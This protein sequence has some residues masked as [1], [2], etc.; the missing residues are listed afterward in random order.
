MIRLLGGVTAFGPDGEIE[1]G[2]PK[3]RAVLALLANQP[4]AVVSVDR[5]AEELWG[6]SPPARS[7]AS[8]RGYVSNLRK[9]LAAIGA[10]PTT[11]IQFRQQGYVLDVAHDDVDLHRFEAAVGHGSA[12]LR[13]GDVAG[14]RRTLHDA[15][16]LWKGP[17]FGIGGETP[18]LS[19][20]VVRLNQRRA[21][22]VEAFTESRLALGEHAEVAADLLAEIGRE[23]YRERMRTQLATALYRSGHQVEALRGL[24]EA[25]R[26]LAEDI[27]IDAGSEIQALE[28]AILRH[29]PELDLRSTSSP[30]PS[31]PARRGKP[32]RTG[33][34][35]FGR[36]AEIEALDVALQGIR[37]GGRCVIV[38]GE[39]GIGKTAL[40]RSLQSAAERL[41]IPVGW[42]RC[43]ES[44]IASPYRSWSTAIR[45]II[46]VDKSPLLASAVAG[47]AER[48]VQGETT[49]NR[50]ATHLAVVRALRSLTTPVVIVID[51]LQW[52]DSATLA[53]LE[54]VAGEIDDLQVLLAVTVRRRAA[55]DLPAVVRDC[56]SELA[57][58]PHTVQLRLVG[59]PDSSVADW[60]RSR[61]GDR[62][63]GE[64][65][66]VLTETTDGNPFYLGEFITLLQ[67]ESGSAPGEPLRLP[68]SLPVA[69]QD[70]IRRRTSRLP[71]ATQAL[72]AIAA[73]IGRRFDL[74]ILATVSDL[75][76]PSTSDALAAAIDAALLESDRTIPGRFAFVHALVSDTL[77]AEHN[78]FDLA[79]LHARVTSAIEQHRAGQ[80]DRW[81]DELAYHAYAGASAGTS[82][83]AIAYAVS[84]ANAS[85]AAQASADEA[86]HLLRAL[87][88]M[89]ISGEHSAPE[90]IGLLTRLGIALRESG[91]LVAGRAALV[92]ACS[93]AES[94]GDDDAIAGALGALNSDDLWAGLDWS[95]FD[96]QVVAMIERALS[97]SDGGPKHVTAL[98]AAALAAELVYLDPKRSE[99]VSAKAVAAAEM[100]GDP[101][102]LARGFLQ[103]YW[104][105]SGS[106][107][108]AERARI[109]DRLIQLANSERLPPHFVP[110]AHLSRVAAAY[111]LGDLGLV[112]TCRASAAASAHPVRTPTAWAHLLYLDASLAL[113]A[114]DLDRAAGGADAVGEALWRVRRF[115][116]SSTRAGLLA[117]IRS[118]QGRVEEALSAISIVESTPYGASICWLKAWIL[119]EA[120]QEKDSA[121]ALAAFD[122]QLADD[123]YRVPLTVAGTLAAARIGDTVFLRRHLA[124]LLPIADRFACVGNGGIV[125]GPVAYAIASAQHAL[126]DKASARA[127]CRA[128]LDMS[129]SLGAPLWIQRADDL[130]TRIG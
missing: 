46:E 52:S 119:A 107:G 93:L 111:E 66:A 30:T 68:A 77:M 82:Q 122:G 17:A 13:L 57:R 108:N 101:L 47:D 72:L 96:Q 56:L 33:P 25:R 130:S 64:V 114:G 36:R 99:L 23:P 35:L 73:V 59:L 38:S 60:L 28:A 65:S 100:A 94:I 50:L 27:G 19:G 86:G 88:V 105:L 123:W 41:E 10:H 18:G 120:N 76:V 51:D 11:V 126:G 104:G 45:R 106:D 112:L 71:P 61:L 20:V 49:A 128:A 115:A 97:R 26:V 69:V 31:T 22:A 53:L 6:D 5:L 34:V 12:Q 109:G 14:A 85:E 116:A 79:R 70:V 98:L 83:K 67:S 113:L 118:E 103:R 129:T 44:A 24:D 21:E 54:F 91:D 29:D 90:R 48:R 9:A 3:Q 78:P 16:Q 42:G 81:L 121:D 8:V 125:L 74:D 75:D 63:V 95:M 62:P 2:G 43:S 92:E 15:L 87:S 7:D 110:L 1:L 32:H 117:V 37:D 89:A 4:G 39:A 124:T 55:H 40:L 102:L 127:H 84:A 58:S 80:L